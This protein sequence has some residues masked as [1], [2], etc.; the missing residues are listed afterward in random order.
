[1]RRVWGKIGGAVGVEV[2]ER[3]DRQLDRGVPRDVDERA[4]GPER[5]VQRGELRPVERDERV[6][7]GLHQLR[8]GRQRPRRCSRTRRPRSPSVEV[9]WVE[10]VE[11]C[12]TSKPARSPTSPA[13]ARI[14]C[15]VE[16][17]GAATVGERLEVQ[18]EG[19]QVGVAPLL[20]LLGGNGHGLEALQGI[21]TQLGHERRAPS[22]ETRGRARRR[23]W[24]SPRSYR[25][26]TETVGFAPA[27]R[28]S[29]S[30]R[31]SGGD[32]LHAS[33][34]P[35]GPLDPEG[36]SSCSS[37]SKVTVICCSGRRS[38]VSVPA[39]IAR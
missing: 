24:C 39:R 8:M 16:V 28:L 29:G 17:L 13:E 34:R 4:T 32:R 1:M 10:S 23:S 6:E 38:S 12:W 5:G 30:G 14:P 20:R 3:L 11:L 15:L 25:N 21:C 33:S 18:L 37:V 9:R 19:R 36:S 31:S 27:R 26:P 22:E 35:S 2:G 7:V